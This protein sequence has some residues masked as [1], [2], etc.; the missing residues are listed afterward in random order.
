MIAAKEALKTLGAAA[1]EVTAGLIQLDGSF[2]SEVG[3]AA[4]N[5]I[6]NGNLDQLTAAELMALNQSGIPL[7]V[8]SF[9]ESMGISEDRVR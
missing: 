3:N 2:G 5:L 8:A 7:S 9:A 6:A 1:D 4:R